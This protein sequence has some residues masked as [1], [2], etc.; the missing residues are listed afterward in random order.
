MEALSLKKSFI[1]LAITLILSVSVFS[2]TEKR[3][4]SRSMHEKV[5]FKHHKSIKKLK[6][7]RYSG[8]GILSVRK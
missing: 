2:C 7:Y 6:T 5:Y 3:Y 8:S 4:I 1:F